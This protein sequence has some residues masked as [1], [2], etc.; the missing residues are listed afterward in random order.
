MY[1]LRC[2]CLIFFSVYSL[3]KAISSNQ[4]KGAY[5]PV[6]KKVFSG[7][8]HHKKK[9]LQE[10][11]FNSVLGKKVSSEKKKSTKQGP[12]NKEKEILKRVLEKYSKT[13]SIKMRVKK[14]LHL[15]LIEQKKE[16]QGELLIKEGGRLRL[17]LKKPEKSLVIINNKI[18]WSVSYPSDPEFDKTIRVL[19][20]SPSSDLRSQFLF[21]SLIGKS[22]LLEVFKIKSSKKKHHNLEYFLEPKKRIDRIKK[23]EININF[24]KSIIEKLTYTDDLSNRTVFS[25]D[26]IRFQEP[27]EDRVFEFVPPKNAEI[28]TL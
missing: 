4:E 6:F 20:F 22:D 11:D 15:N 14:T 17:D 28:T 24:K 8:Y 23:L 26:K 5:K 25:F 2:I 27:L 3:N 1:F 18:I 13:K 21:L 10:R 16:Y 7:P 9:S 19:K 12:G